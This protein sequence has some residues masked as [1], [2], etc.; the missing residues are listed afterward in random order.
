MSLRISCV[1]LF[2]QAKAFG[3]VLMV[4]LKL[5]RK[6]G[7]AQSC[8]R[9]DMSF[10]SKIGID[11]GEHE[12]WGFSFKNSVD[13]FL[14]SWS[15]AV[16]DVPGIWR[17]EIF[18][19]K[20]AEKNQRQWKRCITII[21]LMILWLWSQLHCCCH[22][23]IPHCYLIAV[24]PKKYS[25]KQLVLTPLPLCPSVSILLTMLVEIWILPHNPRT[26]MHQSGNIDKTKPIPMS[27]KRVP[28]S[29]VWT[30]TTRMMG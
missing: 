1:I 30:E 15:T 23:G 21:F 9:G 2:L 20:W 7:E 12:V 28:P 8:L 16:F 26:L 22:I 17:A 14:D 25:L 3:S 24:V 29:K 4:H 11:T 19:S 6:E 5:S 27:D 10:S 18:T 13:L